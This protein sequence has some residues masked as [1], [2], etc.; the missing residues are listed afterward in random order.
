[1]VDGLLAVHCIRPGIRKHAIEQLKFIAVVGRER[2]RNRTV[3]TDDERVETPVRA[4]IDVAHRICTERVD[5][6]ASGMISR[7]QEVIFQVPKRAAALAII[8]PNWAVP[9]LW[10]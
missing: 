8:A 4:V 10:S 3:F 2:R 5:L 9:V 6:L 1:L 7:L